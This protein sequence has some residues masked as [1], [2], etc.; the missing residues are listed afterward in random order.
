M[1]CAFFREAVVLNRKALWSQIQ[2]QSSAQEDPAG[3]TT[4]M[5]DHLKFK[6][7]R[8]SSIIYKERNMTKKKLET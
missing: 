5:I 2:A 6:F 1:C 7:R 8:V 4:D 3:K